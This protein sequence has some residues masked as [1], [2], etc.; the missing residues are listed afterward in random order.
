LMQNPSC[1]VERQTASRS[2]LS[3]LAKLTVWQQSILGL[4]SADF[5]L[6]GL[7]LNHWVFKWFAEIRD[8]AFSH[9][10]TNHSNRVIDRLLSLAMTGTVTWQN[11]IQINPEDLKRVVSELRSETVQQNS[12]FLWRFWVRWSYHQFSHCGPTAINKFSKQFEFFTYFIQSAHLLLLEKVLG[13]LLKLWEF[14]GAAAQ[15]I[16]GISMK[17]DGHMK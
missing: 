1:Q 2:N 10:F 13:S 14:S 15:I 5:D 7:H 9:L 3:Y 11:S 8:S 12:S 17:V 4:S 6:A 16:K